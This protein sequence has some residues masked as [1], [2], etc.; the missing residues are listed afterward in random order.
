MAKKQEL[1]L[2]TGKL[3]GVCGRLMCCLGYEYSETYAQDTALSAE[4]TLTV[5]EETEED[6]LVVASSDSFPE[7]AEPAPQ[8]QPAVNQSQTPQQQPEKPER[9]GKRRWHPKRKRRK[10]H[11]KKVSQ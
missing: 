2:N 3:S 9:K 7:S 8:P 10:F 1:V 5:K 11:Q 6:E 4:E